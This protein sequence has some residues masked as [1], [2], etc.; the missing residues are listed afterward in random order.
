M[1]RQLRWI[2]PLLL[3]TG[4]GCSTCGERKPLF[5]RLHDYFNG[6]DRDPPSRRTAPPA[7]RYDDRFGYAPIAPSSTNC[8]PCSTGGGVVMGNSYGNMTVGTPVILPGTSSSSGMLST[9]TLSAP[10]M[11]R[12]YTSSPENELPQPGNLS[13][14]TPAEMGRSTAP[15]PPTTLIGK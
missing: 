1:L 10:V 3:L 4:I 7:E 11:P 12:G 15:K 13:H 8:L 6:D 9:P 5:P 14:V 2:V